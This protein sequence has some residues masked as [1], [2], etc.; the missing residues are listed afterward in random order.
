M[1]SIHSSRPDLDVVSRFA[2]ADFD[3]RRLDRLRELRAVIDALRHEKESGD[4]LLAWVLEDNRS[5]NTQSD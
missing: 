4:P 1:P 2:A 3:G 5:G